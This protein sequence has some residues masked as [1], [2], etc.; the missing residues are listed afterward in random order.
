M[1]S[2]LCLLGCHSA[3][4]ATTVASG[5]AATSS[6][7][8]TGSTPAS[9]DHSANDPLRVLDYPGGGKIIYG[10]LPHK[11]SV[12]DAMAAMLRMVHNNFGDRPEVGR[13]FQTKGSNS[14]ATFFTFN[15]TKDNN[16]PMSG[17]IIVSAP[18]GGPL[19]GAMLF[20]EAQRFKTSANSMMAKLNEVWQPEGQGSGG[21]EN[22]SVSS[23]PA[24]LH[25][26]AF[27]DNGGSV[28]FLPDGASP[29]ATAAWFTPKA[30]TANRSTTGVVTPVM[31]PNNPQTRQMMMMET[32]GGRLPL[33]GAYVAYPYGGD[34]VRSFI[35]VTALSAQK[36]R[37]PAP[38]YHITST[39]DLGSAP[40]GHCTRAIGDVDRHDGAGL[41]AANTVI[42]ISQPMGGT[43]LMTLYQDNVRPDMVTREQATMDAI[44]KSYKLNAAVIQRE[45]QE[46]VNQIHQIGADS[47]RRAAE[48]HAAFDARNAA[49]AENSDARDRHNQDFTNYLRDNT[50][51]TDTQ[52]GEHATTYNSYA[53]ALVQADPNRYQYVPTQNLLK[54][55]DY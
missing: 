8:N 37:H 42:C 38:T 51:I 13:F 19:A 4:A 55:I 40:T 50:V 35:A 18:P 47:M 22:A 6:P 17:L 30:P 52:T 12:Q 54:G 14:V 29:E 5:P 24:T 43:W 7:S 34:P 9:T 48:S 2:P 31:D 33:P 44:S 20:D 36:Q 21:A 25:Q 45:T 23:G 49:L 46:T 11:A 26:T 53:D 28:G 16:R 1:P 3:P 27:P 15:N 41:L 32:Q 39:K 10:P